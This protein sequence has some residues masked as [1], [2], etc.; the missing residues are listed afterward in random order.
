LNTPAA[1]PAWDALVGASQATPGTV[2][3]FLL[4]TVLS[5]ATAALVCMTSFTRMVVVLGLLRQGLGLPQ[6]PP[7]QV[8]VGLALILTFFVM[9]PT[10]QTVEQ[11]ALTP[12]L[13]DKMDTRTAANHAADALKTFMLRNT[14][15]ADLRLFVELS[16][17]QR[18][19]RG[20]ALGLAVV[21]PAFVLSELATAFRMGLYVLVPM[22]IVDLLVASILMSMGMMM[23]PPTLISLPLKLAV[24][25]LADGWRLVVSALVKS[26]GA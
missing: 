11:Q 4:L 3:M 23:V 14:Q 9:G 19:S 26:F 2:K 6:L 25:V 24:F 20:D 5:F 1:S 13:D 16:G 18:P 17:T 21:A 7:N 15:E 22:L 10:L 12:W 8:L